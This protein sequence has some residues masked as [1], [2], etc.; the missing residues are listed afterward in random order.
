MDSEDF[1]KLKDD[2]IEP[3]NKNNQE[4]F[5]SGEIDYKDSSKKY[6]TKIIIGVLIV[7]VVG[8]AIFLIVYFV[9]GSGGNNNP[10]TDPKYYEKI[11]LNNWYFGSSEKIQ[12]SG[13]EISMGILTNNFYEAPEDFY[14]CTAMGGLSGHTNK[15]YYETNLKNV[16]KTQFDVDW[17]FRS[18]F[19]FN[20]TVSSDNLVLLHINGINYKSDV[21]VDGKQV[22]KRENI[23]GT[24]VKYTLD[25]TRYLNLDSNIHYVVFQIARP[26]NQ[27]GGKSY[28]NE[29]DLAISFVDWNPEAPDSNMGIWQPVDV[30]IFGKKQLTVL[31]SFVRTEIIEDKNINLEIVL[32]FVYIKKIKMVF[33]NI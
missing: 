1:S 6:S 12:F 5:A 22:A 32:S 17:F 25:I 24:F 8:V 4:P 3:S 20:T 18:S 28:E 21:F 7:I 33:Y 14:V 19:E 23:I 13:E 2:Y 31:S 15:Y 27:W 9:G 10:E 30:E 29:T 16:N 11:R 26:H